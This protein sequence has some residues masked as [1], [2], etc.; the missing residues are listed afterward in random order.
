MVIEVTSPPPPPAVAHPVKDKRVHFSRIRR[1]VPCASSVSPPPRPRSRSVPPATRSPATSVSSPP[2][3]SATATKGVITVTDKDPSGVA[4]TVTVFLESNGADAKKV[5]E[6]K[7]KGSQARASPSPS[8]RTGRRTRRTASTSRPGNQVDDADIKPNLT[9][10][11]TACKTEP[12]RRPRRP[13]RPDAVGAPPP[14]RPRRRTRTRRPRRPRRAPPRPAAVA[15][16][17]RRPRPAT[18]TSPRPVP[19]PTPADRR[20]RGRAGRRRRRRRLLRHAPSWGQQLTPLARIA[21]LLTWWPVPRVPGRATRSR[22]PNVARCSQ[23]SSSSRSPRTSNCGLSSGQSAVEGE[24]D[25][26][27]RA[28]QGDGRLLVAAPPDDAVLGE[29]D[30]PTRRSV[31]GARRWRGDGCCARR[32]AAPSPSSCGCVRCTNSTIC[33]HSSIASA[34]ISGATSYGSPAASAASARWTVSLVGHPARPEAR[35]EDPGPGP[36][37]GVRPGLAQRGDDQLPGLGEPGVQRPGVARAS[38]PPPTGT[39]S[40]G[41][42]PPGPA[43]APAASTQRRAPPGV[44]HQPLQRPVRAG[45]HGRGQIGPGRHHRPQQADLVSDFVAVAVMCERVMPGTLCGARSVQHHDFGRVERHPDRVPVLRRLPQRARRL[46]PRRALPGCSR[47]ATWVPRKVRAATVQ[48]RP[49][50]GGR[51]AVPRPGRTS[52]VRGPCGAPVR[53]RHLAPGGVRG[54][55]AA[56]SPSTTLSKPRKRATNSSAGR[57]QTSSGVPDWAIRPSR[58]TTTRSASAK[59]SPWSWVTASTVVPN[60]PKSSRSSTTSRSR[61]ERSSW[62]SGSSSISSRGRGAS[63]RASATRCCS[64]P[65]SAATARPLRRPAARPGPATPA[66]ARRCSLARHA[67]HPQPEGDVAADVPLREELVVLEHQADA[68]AGARARR[69]WSRPS[70]STRPPSERLQSG[71]HPQQRGLAAAAGPEHAHDLVLGDLEVR[72][73]RARPR[74]PNRTV[75]SVQA[76]QRH[77]NSPVRSV[78]IRSSTSSATAHTTIR[79]VRQGHRLAVVELAR[80]GPS[81][82]AT[83]TGSVGLS[84]RAMKTVAPNSP[85]ETAKA[86]PAA[87]SSARRTIGRSTSRQTRQRRRAEHGR[88]LPQPVVH[89]PQHRQHGPHDEGHADQRLRERHQDPGG[90]QVQRRLVERDQE[91]EADGHRG[92]ARAAASAARRSPGPAARALPGQRGGGE[93]ADDQGDDGR[94][95]RRTAA[96]SR[97]PRSA[98]TRKV[99]PSSAGRAPGSRRSRSRR[100]VERPLHQ[101]RE[102][103]QEQ[104][105]DDRRGPRRAAP[106]G[107]RPARPA[108]GPRRRRRAAARSPGAVRSRRARRGSRRPR[109][110]GPASARRPSAGRSSSAVCR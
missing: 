78:R 1:T 66:P 36:H 12:T 44:P 40:S 49:S 89:R 16:T 28:A 21:V 61:S 87:T 11:A 97:S 76:Q 92:D 85:S 22:Q 20:Y 107:P 39:W 33:S 101:H 47:T 23:N 86:K 68:R 106:T 35:G 7:V 56:P 30:R 27:E 26:G 99:P 4:A 98:A 34:A 69:A 62:P 67:V 3:P 73:R 48:R 81:S 17:P 6:Q 104:H 64:P 46:Q 38:G 95:E 52:S 32:R 90:A 14:R 59:A 18:P 24:H 15:T 71:D 53:H 13:R 103:Q 83:A 96:S 80:P 42:L 84:G 45:R 41:D 74:S 65:E 9:T 72:P 58:I 93:P 102:R 88:R 10:P 75:A 105:G 108:R 55:A 51:R 29:L 94:D 60:R 77:Q 43:S 57:C 54:L 82:R 31:D 79:I 91:A 50:V 5:G 19:A 63:A 70:S 25:G 2:T 109:R 8:R 37:L 110:T 100:G